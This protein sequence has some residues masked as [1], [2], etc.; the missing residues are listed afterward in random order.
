MHP[1]NILMGLANCRDLEEVELGT[2]WF[3]LSDAYSQPKFAINSGEDAAEKVCFCLLNV[4][5]HNTDCG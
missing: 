1:V 3:S 5:S 4:V 2:I